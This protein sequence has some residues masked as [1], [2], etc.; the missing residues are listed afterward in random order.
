MQCNC[1]KMCP[2]NV[3]VHMIMIVSSV[4]VVLRLDVVFYNVVCRV[5][6]HG[7]IASFQCIVV[8]NIV[9]ASITNYHGSFSTALVFRTVEFMAYDYITCLCCMVL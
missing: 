3:V 6:T 9:I 4:A 2:V 7:M 8:L 1:F 5:H